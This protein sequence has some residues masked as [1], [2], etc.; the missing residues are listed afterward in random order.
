MSD[1][2]EN[3]TK[4]QRAKYK[5][6]SVYANNECKALKH[7]GDKKIKKVLMQLYFK[8]L[9]KA[10]STRLS[11]V[12]N[13]LKEYNPFQTII[14]FCSKTLIPLI[15]C[16]LICFIPACK[17]IRY[18]KW[19]VM[20]ILI[21]FATI[22]LFSYFLQKFYL[23]S[24]VFE[25]RSEMVMFFSALLGTILLSMYCI[26]SCIISCILF[27]RFLYLK[28]WRGYCGIASQSKG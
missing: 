7:V 20:V 16:L 21:A 5:S 23:D 25:L 3:L 2:T 17:K 8:K 14:Y 15:A 6:N 10:Y 28:F 27:F 4:E 19:K 13:T 22:P 26:Y 24:P 12:S 11:W 9:M 1:N 18:G